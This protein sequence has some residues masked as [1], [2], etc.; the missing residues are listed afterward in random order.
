MHVLCQVTAG[1]FWA[2]SPTVGS[3]GKPGRSGSLQHQVSDALSS[4]AA[5]TWCVVQQ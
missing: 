2:L 4:Y 3:L 5:R 1:G